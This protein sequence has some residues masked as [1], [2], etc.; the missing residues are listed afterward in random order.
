MAVGTRRGSMQWW[1]MGVGVM[2]LFAAAWMLAVATGHWVSDIPP[3]MARMLHKGI[4][5]LSHY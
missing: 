2:T 3:E 1:V 5:H 4:E